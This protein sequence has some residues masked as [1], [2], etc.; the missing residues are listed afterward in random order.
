MDVG[1]YK[2][3]RRALKGNPLVCNVCGVNNALGVA[4]SHLGPISFAYCR[5]CIAHFA[6][7]EAMFE[8]LLNEFTNTDACPAE[9]L[10]NLSTF[11]DGEYQSWTVWL[12][13]HEGS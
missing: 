13:N 3:R 6:E 11:K 8:Y 7:P 9:W 1:N 5:E 10:D 4:A 2:T 12:A